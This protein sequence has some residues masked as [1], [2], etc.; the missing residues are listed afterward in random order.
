MKDCLHFSTIVFLSFTTFKVKHNGSNAFCKVSGLLAL[1]AVSESC[2]SAAA[3]LSGE[4]HTRVRGAMLWDESVETKLSVGI[5]TGAGILGWLLNHR[6]HVLEI[7]QTAI[8]W[9]MYQRN[10]SRQCVTCV[11]YITKESVGTETSSKHACMLV[12]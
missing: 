9:E 7:K 11:E 12:Y 3:F 1:N 4:L 5:S 8:L 10:L 2:A 6:C